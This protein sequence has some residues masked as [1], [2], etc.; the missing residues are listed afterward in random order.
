M[1]RNTGLTF[2][3]I[4]CV[5]LIG[6][7]TLDEDMGLMGYGTLSQD[8]SLSNQGFEELLRGNYQQAEKYLEEALSLNPVNPYALLNMGVV[9]QNTG[10]ISQARL[11]YI[12]VIAHNP[13]ATAIRSSRRESTGKTVVEIARENLQS[14][15]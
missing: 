10:R 8:M 15:Q 9:Y 3:L 13:D 5:A 11:M 12:K 7:A 14:L 4:I 6:C 1:M 2:I